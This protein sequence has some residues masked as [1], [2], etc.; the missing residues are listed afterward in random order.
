[1]ARFAHR[2]IKITGR[3]WCESVEV[4]GQGGKEWRGRG[5]EGE[6]EREEEDGL[7]DMIKPIT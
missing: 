2:D 7:I 3:L 4:C 6:R 1:M 5:R